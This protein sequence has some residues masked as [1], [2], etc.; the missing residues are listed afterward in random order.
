[1]NRFLGNFK[2]LVT[3]R[4]LLVIPRKR[5]SDTIVE[6][7]FTLLDVQNEILRLEYKDYIAGPL[8]DSDRPGELWEF[9]KKIQHETV[10]VKLKLA[11]GIKPICLSFHFP[12][13]EV[14]YYFK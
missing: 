12:E 3:Q 11:R 7:G 9:G 2:T 14:S 6:I 10:Y 8:Q 4:G 1:M 5:N 13:R